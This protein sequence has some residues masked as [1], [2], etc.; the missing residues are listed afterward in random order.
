MTVEWRTFCNLPELAVEG[1]AVDVVL[2]DD[3]RHQVTITE[4]ADEYLFCAIVARRSIVV[5]LPDVAL[6][7]WVR[8]RAVS[9]V[10]FRVDARGRLLAEAW[11]PKAGITAA[12]FQRYLQAIAAEADRFE[13]VLTGRDVE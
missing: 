11:A 10:G 12:E 13:Y 6:R 5:K 8:N 2:G 9:L 4:G 1:S 3:R 7:A